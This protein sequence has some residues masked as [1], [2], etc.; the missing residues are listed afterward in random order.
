M[1]I[2]CLKPLNGFPV[3]MGKAESLAQITR[4]S[5]LPYVYPEVQ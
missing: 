4:L 2:P 3:P 1:S 5:F